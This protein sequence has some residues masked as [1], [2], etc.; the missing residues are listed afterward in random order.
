MGGKFKLK[1][2]NILVDIGHPAHVHYS[3]N[4]IKLWK[5]NGHK[6]FITARDKEVIKSLLEYYDLPYINRGK[7]K[8]SRFGKLI[9]MFQADVCLIKIA[10][11]NNIDIF[12]SFSS[13]YAA[14]TAYLLGKPHIAFND[15]EHTDKMHAK[16]T[17]PFS[18]AIITPMSYQNDLG[19]KQ[20][21]FNNIDD[22][23][24][25]NEGYFSPDL[26][27]K[28]DLQIEENEE[29]VILRFVSWNAHH[30]FGQSGLD[31]ETKRE[32]VRLLSKR[33]KVFISSED[34]L[35]EEFK[36]YQIKILPEKMHDVLASA[37]LFVGESGTMA[38]ES[39]FLGTPAVYVN[40]LP[41]M[42]YL[43]LEQDAGILKHFK[44]SK[45]IVDYV[46]KLIDQKDLKLSANK[47]AKI[48]RKDFID[49]TKF[50]VWFIE[51]FPNSLTDFQENPQIQNKF[52]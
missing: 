3:R 16:F 46:S 19:P 2:M 12:L 6:V 5:E 35:P 13:P 21:R 37:S 1:E 43:K 32:L 23:L 30:D 10:R 11:K 38:S 17:Y 41:L 24:Y 4:A 31:I 18:K 51:E 33:F 14:Q 25:L 7:G 52:R 45:G 27:I 20:V 8:N 44:T 42:C 28:K 9:Y 22:G 40:S 48:M 34:E 36:L 50:L 15:T 26:D 47:K 39:S 29:Y 49:P